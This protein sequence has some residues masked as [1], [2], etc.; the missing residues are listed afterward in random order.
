MKADKTKTHA[1]A[2]LLTGAVVWGLIWYPFR[3]LEDQG[4]FGSVSTAYVYGVALAV[5]LLLSWRELPRAQGYGMVLLWIGLVAGWTN[6]AYVIAIIE[7]EVMRVM[8]L[9]YLAPLWTVLFARWL[10]YEKPGGIGLLVILISATGAVTMLWNPTQGLPIPTNRAEW[11]GLSAGMAFALSNVLIRKAH[12]V[13]IGLKSLAVFAG[14]TALA[15]LWSLWTSPMRPAPALGIASF[16]LVVVLALVILATN[17]A[18]Q[19]GIS[20][21]PATQAIVILLF[22]LVVA[23]L[24]SYFL[25]GEAM[26]LQEWA[27][28]AL[29]VAA[30]LLS[31]RLGAQ[32]VP[33]PPVLEP[34]ASSPSCT[35]G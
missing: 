29:I 20:K 25:A 34:D 8:L 32:A 35:R 4:L 27:G 7:G 1:I 26:T 19:Y 33:M 23:A 12:W 11:L 21:T 3:V 6:L 2:G 17:W 9:F 14:V 13:G 16:G 22:E 31:G 15:V 30:S 5:A 10:L 28:G 24:G 18:V